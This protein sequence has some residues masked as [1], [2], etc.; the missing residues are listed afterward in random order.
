MNFSENFVVSTQFKDFIEFLIIFFV[1][2]I[3]NNYSGDGLI[4]DWSHKSVDAEIG[5]PEDCISS[6]IAIDWE[7]YKNWDLVQITQNYMKLML[8]YLQDNN[9]GLLIHC[10]SGMIIKVY[11]P[12]T[13]LKLIQ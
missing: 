13:I 10:I 2:I 5:V 1:I 4:F 11:C 12:K 8:K 7:K 6:Q 3:D 9:S